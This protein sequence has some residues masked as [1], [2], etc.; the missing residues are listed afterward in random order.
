[1]VEPR[2][3][4]VRLA[5]VDLDGTLLDGQ[6]Q[7]LFLRHLVARRLASPLLLLRVL[8]WAMA[9]RLGLPLDIPKLHRQVVAGFAGIEAARLEGALDAFVKADLA[10]RI[11]HQGR[12]EVQRLASDGAEVVL[13]SGSLEPL[14]ARVRPLVAAHGVVATRLAPP[15]AGSVAGLLEGE[16]LIGAAKAAALRAY[17]DARHGAGNWVLWRAYGDHETDIPLL[18]TAQEPVAVCPTPRLAAVARARGWPVVRWE[19]P[20]WRR[21][22]GRLWNGAGGADAPDRTL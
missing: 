8:A 9:Y 7:A 18:A 15:L 2:P 6:S 13:V 12:H 17:A 14:V 20:G 16:T 1:M 11:R 19:S 3:R 22:N 21:P 5:A 10:A 4:V